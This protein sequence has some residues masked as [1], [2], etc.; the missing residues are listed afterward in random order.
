MPPLAPHPGFAQQPFPMPPGPPPS[1]FA[2]PLGMPLPPPPP[3]VFAAPFQPGAYPPPP[4]PGFFPRNTQSPATMHDPLANISHQ[5]VQAQRPNVPL[6]PPHPSLPSKPAAAKPSLAKSETATVF[7]APELRDFKKEATAFVP[8]ALKRKKPAATA[9]S[10]KVNAA[11]DT[12]DMDED[13]PGPARPDLLDAL[14]GQF[15]PASASPPT[16]KAKVD[17]RSDYE[18][19][20]EDMGDDLKAPNA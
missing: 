15:G 7:A 6:P 12:G 18:K 20:M 3:G 1:G 2:L 9:S 19:W 5:T 14:K 10:T 16:K 8:T 17:E 11:P 13:V 4:P